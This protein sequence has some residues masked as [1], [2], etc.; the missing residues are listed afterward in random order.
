MF[1]TAAL[2]F[3]KLDAAAVKIHFSVAS[4]FKYVCVSCNAYLYTMLQRE[5]L[6][7]WCED[8]LPGGRNFDGEDDVPDECLGSTSFVRPDFR[9]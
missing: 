3:S 6:P 5:G 4:F 9:R 1:P 2:H 7:E 8:F